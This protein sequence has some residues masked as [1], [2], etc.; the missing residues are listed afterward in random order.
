[1]HEMSPGSWLDCEWFGYEDPHAQRSW[2]IG[3]G[4]HNCAPLRC[5]DVKEIAFRVREF[6]MELGVEV[7][8]DNRTGNSLAATDGRHWI[9]CRWDLCPWKELTS[10][11]HE[12]VHVWR[13]DVAGRYGPERFARNEIFTGVTMFLLM[14]KL[15]WNFAPEL[16]EGH[17]QAIPEVASV[18]RSLGR[19]LKPLFR[20]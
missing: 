17:V 16:S 13:G 5:K 11:L 6:I 3:P 14:S 9:K 18:V 7:R 10:L 4:C 8:F 19:K 1:M 15:G 2:T 12:L 20:V